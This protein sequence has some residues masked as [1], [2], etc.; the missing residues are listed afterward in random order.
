MLSNNVRYLSFQFS[1]SISFI[2]LCILNARFAIKQILFINKLIFLNTQTIKL[3]IVTHC[4]VH[5]YL[6]LNIYLY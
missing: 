2:Y 4:S 5:Q 6:Y 3:I 1:L